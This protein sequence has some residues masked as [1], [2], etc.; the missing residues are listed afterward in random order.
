MSQDQN[1]H[2]TIEK[3]DQKRTKRLVLT[4]KVAKWWPIY[5]KSMQ[6]FCWTFGTQPNPLA[7][8]RMARAAVKGITPWSKSFRGLKGRFSRSFSA[9][10]SWGGGSNR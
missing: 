6:L 1:S 9:F 8:E 7:V 3:A 4:V 5:C 2:R 10:K